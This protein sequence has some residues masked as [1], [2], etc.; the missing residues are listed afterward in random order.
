MERRVNN[1]DLR[2]IAKHVTPLNVAKWILVVGF[3]GFVVITLSWFAAY[4]W[5]VS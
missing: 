2:A 4:A 3:A 5:S 1:L